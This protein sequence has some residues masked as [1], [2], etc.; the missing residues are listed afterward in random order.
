MKKLCIAATFAVLIASPAFAQQ[1][2]W[3]PG[4]GQW[5]VTAE[6]GV[7]DQERTMSARDMNDMSYAYGPGSYAYAP[8]YGSSYAYAPAYG[9]FGGERYMGQRRGISSQQRTMNAQ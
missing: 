4:A 2:F 6:Q 7:S 5:Q 1:S 3:Q 8:A 9:S